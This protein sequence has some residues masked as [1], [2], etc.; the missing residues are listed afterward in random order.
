MDFLELFNAVAR[1]AK[2]AVANTMQLVVDNKAPLKELGFDSLDM[3]IILIDLC[4]IFAIPEQVDK[5][6]KP[7]T[8]SDVITFI[9]EN[10]TRMPGSVKEALSFIS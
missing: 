6:F 7:A 8:L 9:T 1:Q 3:L 10:A 5:Q 4:E 2:P